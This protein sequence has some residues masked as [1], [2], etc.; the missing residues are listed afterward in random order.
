MNGESETTIT[1]RAARRVQAVW[2]CLS[3][4]CPDLPLAERKALASKVLDLCRGDV[5]PRVRITPAQ[6]QEV[7]WRNMQCVNRH[8]PMVLFSREI[9]DELNEF[10]NASE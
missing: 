7:V 8:C 10:F 3:V 4:L 6:V 9:A 5:E 1:E 2:D